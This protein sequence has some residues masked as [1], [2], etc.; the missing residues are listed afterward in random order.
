VFLFNF[1]YLGLKQ[2]TGTP[3]FVQY[4]LKE[5]KRRKIRTVV[6]IS[7]YTIAVAFLIIIVTLSQSYNLV[8]NGDLQAIGT[9]FAVYIPASIDCPCQ[10]GEVGPYFKGVY[11]P[12]F[13]SSVIESIR[14]MRGV[15]DAAPCLMFK[16]D[17]LTISGLNF[18][19]LATQTTTI[20]EVTG[21]QPNA[22]SSNEIMLD[23]VYAKVMNLNV[24][25]TLLAFNY[26]FTVVGITDPSLYSKPAGIANIYAN[27]DT[28][29]EIARHYGELYDFAVSDINVVL[30][31]ISAKG[32]DQSIGQVE[33]SVLQ[34]LESD[35]GTSGAI[36]GYQC[37]I[38]ARKVVSINE[39]SAWMASAI[40]LACI[41]LFSIRSQFG[42]VVERTKD[43]GVLKAIGWQ[44]SDITKQIFIESLL[45]GLIGGVIG[46]LVGC[47]TLYVLPLFGL[48]A[49]QNLTLI[50][51]PWLVLLGLAVSLIGGVL[52]GVIPGWHA[53]KLQ[54]AEAIK[55]L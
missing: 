9:H 55:H 45:Q 38:L 11:T 32:D 40:L 17:N 39:D 29:Q 48:V 34:K 5:I 8:A 31:E 18:T 20:G 25:D 15:Q 51:S 54:P 37:G 13:N 22:N 52:A 12:T 21:R 41:T 43:I 24:G 26:N 23:S 53:A 30:V 47:L 46:V 44:N 19:A 3:M 16:L 49:T 6:N 7:G 27:L 42:S 10:L 33:Q 1:K 35:V 36:V 50:I 14:E 4:A 28:V 2:L